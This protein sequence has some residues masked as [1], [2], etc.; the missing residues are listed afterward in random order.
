MAVVQQSIEDRGGHHLIAKI[1]PPLHDGPI[2]GDQHAAA[3]VAARDQ[4]EPLRQGSI[5]QVPC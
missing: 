4:L 3:L 1:L 5:A 2:G